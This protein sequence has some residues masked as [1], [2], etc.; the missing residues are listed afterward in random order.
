MPRTVVSFRS[1]EHVED[2]FGAV[3]VRQVPKRRYDTD[4][5]L[6]HIDGADGLFVHSENDYDAELIE[7][8]PTLRVIAKPGSGIDNI[9]LETATDHGVAV[10]HTPGMNAVAVAEFTVGALLAHVR[11][12]PDASDHLERGG[13]RSPDWWG[14]ELRGKTVGIV[15]LGSAGLETA[16]RLQ[17]FCSNLLAYDPYTSDD[18]FATVNAERVSLEALLSKSDVVSVHVRLT[19]ETRGMIGR[20]E[21]E[22][23]RSDAVLIN[24][25]RGAVVDR[26]ALLQELRTDGIGGA[27]IDVFDEEPPSADDRLVQCD[28]VL[29]T[30]HLAG[31]TY[32]TRT[33]ML[34]VTA[35]NLVD[36]LSGVSVDERYVANPTVLE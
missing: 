20:T 4:E 14:R 3:T 8:S 17:P 35:K 29:T 31:A 10:L 12:I 33:Q 5:L 7:Q 25:A 2:S 30:P 18:R 32:E 16:K 24:T 15:G 28:S 9:D 1:I 13:W 6:T 23:M 21:L 27:V 26:D 19:P 22:K 11:R 36:Y 34:A